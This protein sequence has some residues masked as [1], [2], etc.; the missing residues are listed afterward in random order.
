MPT[1]SSGVTSSQSADESEFSPLYRDLDEAAMIG[2][3]R[4][5]RL[6]TIRLTMLLAAAFAGAFTLKWRSADVAGIIAAGAFGA[7]L[8]TEVHLLG[9]RPQQL[10][11]DGRAAA[12]SA[13]TLIWRY[14]SGGRPFA[15]NQVSDAE[16]DRGLAIAFR[17]ITRLLMGGRI[18]PPITQSAQITDGMRRIRNLPLTARRA[19]YLANRLGDQQNWYAQKSRWHE[20]RANRWSVLLASLEAIGIVGGV[21]KGA[22]I[23]EIDLL[24]VCGAVIAAGTAWL[25]VRQHTTLAFIYALTSQAIAEIMP[26]DALPDNE[27]EWATMVHDV[28]R[29]IRAPGS[30]RDAAALP[31]PGG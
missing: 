9:S 18:L 11:Y 20:R 2:Q 7:A 8:V 6:T 31:F 12:E 1:E 10:W 14:V 3:R 25:E 28:E 17:E 4:Y 29:A 26:L 21:L 30:P 23:V 27:D 15:K 16:A 24:G 5:L 22:G 19:H 13:K